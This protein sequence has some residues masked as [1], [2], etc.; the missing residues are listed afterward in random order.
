MVLSEQ[1][2]QLQSVLP[3]LS[4]RDRSFASDLIGC[5]R[6]FGSLSYRQE[7]WV[8]K[9]IDKATPRPTAGVSVGEFAGVIEL[10]KTGNAKLKFPKIRLLCLDRPVI[11]SLAGAQSKTPGYV[12][13]AGEGQYPNRE[14]FGRVSPDGVW[15]PSRTTSQEM[16]EALVVLLQ[17]LAA[18][19]AGVARQ[20][21]KLTGHCCFCGLELTDPRSTHAGFGEICSKHYGLH[22]QWKTA[23]NGVEL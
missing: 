11:L 10:F 1:I 2:N 15:E 19:P 7:P 17:T 6:R 3:A 23:L 5:Y 4:E 8:V 13:I 9:L 16:R 21:G 22:E 18:D 14:W 20:Y 12:N